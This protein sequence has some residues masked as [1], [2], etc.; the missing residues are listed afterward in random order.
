[1]LRVALTHDVD[2]I[3]KTYQYF[4]H[5]VKAAKRKYWAG[6]KYHAA[7]FSERNRVYWNFDD[8][9]EI[10]NKFNVKS[11]FYFLHETL[12][13]R[14]FDSFNWPLSLGRYCLSEEKVVEIIRSLHKG[15]WEIG[16]HG[17]FNSYKSLDL[18]KKEK[19]LLEKILGHPVNGIRQHWLNLNDETWQLQKQAG[20]IYDTSWGYNEHLGFRDNKVRPFAPFN[21]SFMVYPMPIMD[22]TYM[23]AKNRL[24]ELKKLIELVVSNNSILVVNWH[25]NNYHE[26]EFPGYKDAY[27]EVIDY[28]ISQGAEFDTLINFHSK[29]N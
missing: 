29:Q 15:G 10:E 20:F 13:F 7:S 11:T 8:I 2:R 22:A 23:K 27:I 1:M 12:P 3:K 14:L 28:C 6:V 16:L 17:S 21:D 5:T 26:K 9:I 24:D 25:S 4:T 19:A 18:L